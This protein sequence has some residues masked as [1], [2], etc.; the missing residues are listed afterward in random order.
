M[1]SSR[2][3]AGIRTQ[4]TLSY[5]M[6]CFLWAVSNCFIQTCQKSHKNTKCTGLASRVFQLHV[7]V[8]SLFGP[9]LQMCHADCATKDVCLCVRWGMAANELTPH[10]Y[11]IIPFITETNLMCTEFVRFTSSNETKPESKTKRTIWCHL[12][13]SDPEICLDCCSQRQLVTTLEKGTF[14]IPP[15]HWLSSFLCTRVNQNRLYL[16]LHTKGWFILST[17]CYCLSETDKD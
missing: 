15:Y 5:F 16:S 6:F 14:S 3:P 11:N 4:F 10:G 12:S 9:V 2:V 13:H 1:L 17:A 8:L 7:K